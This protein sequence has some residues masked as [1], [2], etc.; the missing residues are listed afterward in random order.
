MP[1]VNTIKMRSWNWE[2]V[3]PNKPIN[4]PYVEV[5]GEL[6][7]T[8]SVGGKLKNKTITVCPLKYH[9]PELITK[10]E[11]KDITKVE[12]SQKISTKG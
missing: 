9:F 3:I 2:G 7:A 6:Y 4:T 8:Y 10:I 1:K 12:V 11:E 5:D